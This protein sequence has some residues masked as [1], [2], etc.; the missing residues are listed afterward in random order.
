M[1]LLDTSKPKMWKIR[2]GKGEVAEVPALIVL[3]PGP[4]KQAVEAAVK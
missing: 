2:N 3:I 1:L 4:D